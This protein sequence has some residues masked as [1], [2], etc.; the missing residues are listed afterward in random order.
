[1][2]HFA[3]QTSKIAQYAEAGIYFWA[4]F[5]VECRWISVL[6]HL[7]GGFKHLTDMFAK[8]REFE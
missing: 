5:A 1:V 3:I 6:I 2:W 7:T 8:L 4:L